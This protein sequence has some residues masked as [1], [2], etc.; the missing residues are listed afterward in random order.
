M[1][2]ALM[3][4][5]H[6]SRALEVAW[7]FLRAADPA[8]AL[9][10]A[11]AGA[12]AALGVGAPLEA[13]QVLSVLLPTLSLGTTA[14]ACKLLLARALVDQSKADRAMPVLDELCTEHHLDARVFAEPAPVRSAA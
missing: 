7:H 11:L 2:E 13:E 12:K 9:P 10:L 4:S 8:R 3:Q 14:Q 1:R 5:N 6:Q